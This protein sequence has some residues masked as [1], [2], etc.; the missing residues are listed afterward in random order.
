[1]IVVL[2]S[3]SCQVECEAGFHQSGVNATACAVCE[4]GSFTNTTASSTCIECPLGTYLDLSNHDVT[5]WLQ[6]RSNFTHPCESCPDGF[7][8]YNTGAASRLSCLP[9]N[10]PI[11]NTVRN[12]PDGVSCVWE[13]VEHSRRLDVVDVDGP[14]GD[15]VFE[16]L[17][18]RGFSRLGGHISTFGLALLGGG[19]S[20]LDFAQMG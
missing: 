10:Y 9:E 4:P 13:V 3:M 17:S 15:G 14:P 16:S 8:T 2:L 11:R 6:S 5:S 1:M 12:C 20:V 7:T 18:V 19:I